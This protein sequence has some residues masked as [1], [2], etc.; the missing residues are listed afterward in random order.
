MQFPAR[1]IIRTC[2]ETV[3]SGVLVTA[4]VLA[5]PVDLAAAGSDRVTF[6]MIVSAGAANCLPNATANV[7]IDTVGVNQRMTVQAK[8]LA[9]NAD[10]T[11]FVLQVPTSPF[12]MA[13]YQGDLHTGA[14]GTATH[15]FFGIF[16]IETHVLA[17]GSVPAPQTDPGVDAE[18]NPTTAPVH[19]YHLGIWFADPGDATAAGCPGTVTPFDGDHVAGIQVLNTRNFPDLAGPLSQVE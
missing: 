1:R 9:P 19:M 14:G 16:S 7:A 12:G 4:A 8:G 5:C 2:L 17:P 15:Q 6:N 18:T 10:Y 3:T 11:I 13:W